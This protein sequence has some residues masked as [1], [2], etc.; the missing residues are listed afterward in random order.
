MMSEMAELIL[1]EELADNGRRI[2]DIITSRDGFIE[3][4]TWSKFAPAVRK[5]RKEQG[6]ED[7]EPEAGK[8]WLYKVYYRVPHTQDKLV[9]EQLKQFQD[10]FNRSCE[11][12]DKL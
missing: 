3:K 12:Y 2:I 5:I 8:V 11:L 1:R 9:R 4:I 10:S 7:E 6:R